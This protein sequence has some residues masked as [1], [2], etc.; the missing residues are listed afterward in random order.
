M[1]RNYVKLSSF[2][3]SALS[4]LGEGDV[5]LFTISFNLSASQEK[6]L[7]NNTGDHPLLGRRSINVINASQTLALLVFH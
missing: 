7:K 2:T 5:Q 4:S 6:I 3:F 1:M